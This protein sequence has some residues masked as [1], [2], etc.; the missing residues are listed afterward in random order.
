MCNLEQLIYNFLDTLA[1]IV[2]KVSTS[3]S[4]CISNKCGDKEAPV[5]TFVANVFL[6]LD[7]AVNFSPEMEIWI[8]LEMCQINYNVYLGLLVCFNL[9]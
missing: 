3:L 2:K 1:Y 6:T 5:A 9:T 7:T 4:Q 8:D